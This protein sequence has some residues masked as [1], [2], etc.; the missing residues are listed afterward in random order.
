MMCGLAGSGKSTY[1]KNNFKDLPIVSRDILRAQLGFTKSADHKAMLSREDEDLVTM[2]QNKYINDLCSADKDF[3]L[4]NQNN[5]KCFRQDIENI[6]RQYPNMQIVVVKMNTPLEKCIER[7][8][9]QIPAH[10]M[11]SIHSKFEYP[12]ED[13]Y[14]DLIDVPYEEHLDEAFNGLLK[15]ELQKILLK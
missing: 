4:D 10:I 1:I 3:V 14:D 13:E 12:T 2:C 6:V 15:Q 11:R 7:R 9:G 5:R 8:K